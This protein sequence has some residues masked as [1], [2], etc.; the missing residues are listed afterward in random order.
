MADLPLDGLGTRGGKREHNRHEHHDQGG[1]AEHTAMLG[2][3][4]FI[5][6]DGNPVSMRAVL[7]ILFLLLLVPAVSAQEVHGVVV[8]HEENGGTVSLASADNLTITASPTDDELTHALLAGGEQ[9]TVYGSS[10]FIVMRFDNVSIPDPVVGCR[11][12]SV[13]EVPMSAE[14]YASDHLPAGVGDGRLIG[15]FTTVPKWHVASV[16]SECVHNG[17]TYLLLIFHGRGACRI[18]EVALLSKRRAAELTGRYFLDISRLPVG[19]HEVSSAWLILGAVVCLGSAAIFERRPRR[20][21]TAGTIAFALP[22]MVQLT[23]LNAFFLSYVLDGVAGLLA[24]YVVYG[25]IMGYVY[26]LR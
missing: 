25:A 12:R 11:V 4:V 5:R 18:D 2:C 16:P 22:L 19:A 21:A 3:K 14:I 23:G 6:I 20:L 24:S 7:C 8:E 15:R 10:P 9:V 1:D 13:F 17:T 26:H